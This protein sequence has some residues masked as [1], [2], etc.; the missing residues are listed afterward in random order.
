MMDNFRS[1]GDGPLF[2]EPARFLYELLLF[3]LSS[4][5]WASAV[6]P[7]F[8]YNKSNERIL[9][10]PLLGPLLVS[11]FFI[12]KRWVEITWCHLVTH[13][14]ISLPLSLTIL[15]IYR[16]LLASQRVMFNMS[17]GRWIHGK[18]MFFFCRWSRNLE[19]KWLFLVL[20]YTKFSR[21]NAKSCCPC[22][23]RMA[24]HRYNLYSHDRVQKYI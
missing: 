2:P 15:L 14:A 4:G 24:F 13:V 22:K 1:R 6:P 23:I 11:G 3:S 16:S 17:D 20:L 9:I 5:C 19:M 12:I 7:F 18:V 8:F 21:L 10:N